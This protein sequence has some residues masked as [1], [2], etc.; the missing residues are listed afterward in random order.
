[1]HAHIQMIALCIHV[2]ECRDAACSYEPVP[3]VQ[4]ARCSFEAGI[5]SLKVFTVQAGLMQSQ[6]DGGQA[7]LR[8]L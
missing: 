5:K 1:M 7:P 6:S 8:C 4:D 3:A 2:C